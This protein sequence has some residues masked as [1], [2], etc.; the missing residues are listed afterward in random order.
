M[1]QICIDNRVLNAVKTEDLVAVLNAMIDTE[2]SKSEN[3]IDTQFVDECVDAIIQLEAQENNNACLIPLISSDKFLKA[4]TASNTGFKR[5]SVMA[6]VAIVAAV[7]SCTTF[8]ANAAIEAVTGVDVIETVVQ[9]VSEQISAL[10][11]IDI[12]DGG[13]EEDLPTTTAKNEATTTPSAQETQTTTK[14]QASTTT[15]ATTTTKPSQQTKPTSTTTANQVITPTQTNKQE[16]VM[17]G[18]EAVFDNFKTDYIYG[19]ELTYNGL[20]LYKVYS[21]GSKQVLP[22]EE[23]QYTKS[24][25]MNVTQDITLKIIYN[26]TVI[27]ADITIRPDEDSRGSQI[28]S[29]A[30]YDYLLCDKGVYLTAYH[31][32]SKVLAFETINGNKVFAIGAGV[33][34]SSD[35]TSISIPYV[36]RIFDSAFEGCA[37][38]ESCQAPSAVYIGNNAFAGCE[39][40]EEPSFSPSLSHIG[41]GAYKNSGIKTLHL[42]SAITKVPAYLCDGC[43]S[44]ASVELEGAVLEIGKYAFCECKSLETVTGTEKITDVGDFAF[45]NCEKVNFAFPSALEKAGSNAFFFCQKLEIG[46]VPQTITS[47]GEQAFAY[48][49][50]ITQISVPQSITT[51]PYGAFRATNAKSITLHDG[52][53][54][55]GDYAFMS[56]KAK[57][58]HLPAGLEAIG[59]Y[60]LYS[61]LLRDVYF[62][63]NVNQIGENAF[64]IGRSTTFHLYPN[65][66]AQQYAMD[67]GVKYEILGNIDNVEGGID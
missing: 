12:I 42:P 67:N 22:L 30:L 45:Y 16:A 58:I 9:T 7:V 55:I 33:F 27:T 41:E 24:V 50:G 57:E 21:D 65:T 54:A 62:D 44:L 51:I 4:L 34:K 59:E 26:T 35:I 29:N 47:I 53:T 19:E 28:C 20:T 63:K 39:K 32:N 1:A 10:R 49:S 37:S 15:P 5:L 56:H 43:D 6:R 48:C 66:Y 3:L 31:G 11:G 13:I 60:A 46:A 64:Y 25:N 61:V 52:V 14:P 36:E 40:L 23:C 8:T 38:L 2:L 17:T 18:I